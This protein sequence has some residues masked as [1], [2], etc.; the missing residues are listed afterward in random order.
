[1]IDS[2]NRF[3]LRSR[4]LP[5][6]MLG[7]KFYSGS[8]FVFANSYSYYNTCNSINTDEL[9]SHLEAT[10]AEYSRTIEGFKMPSEKL[11][12]NFKNFCL[13]VSYLIEGDIDYA[14]LLGNGS[15]LFEV[16]SNN[17]ELSVSIGEEHFSYVFHDED[18]PLFKKHRV[19]INR[20]TI[21]D[22]FLDS[23]K[24]F[25]GENTKRFAYSKSRNYSHMPESALNLV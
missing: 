21:F 1:M 13:C 12:S 3:F 11:Y 24:Y 6:E 17:A 7:S 22:F 25:S 2:R 10:A 14:E 23:I 18:S 16:M 8:N 9:I 19:E 20:D 15:I 4:H 5:F